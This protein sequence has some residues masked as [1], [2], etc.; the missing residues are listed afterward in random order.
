MNENVQMS[1]QPGFPIGVVCRMTGIAQETLRAWERRYALVTPSRAGGRNRLYSPDDV[2]RISLVKALVDAGHPVGSVASL[3]GAQLE[4]LRMATAPAVPAAREA[5]APPVLQASVAL[6]PGR[7]GVIGRSLATRLLGSP[8]RPTLEGAFSVD[9]LVDIAPEHRAQVLVLEMPTVQGDAAE[10]LAGALGRTGAGT[11]VVLYEFGARGAVASLEALGAI[12]LKGP[13]DPVAVERACAT[14]LACLDT[15]SERRVAGLPARRFSAE[16][17]ARIVARAPAIACECP[18]HLA[19]LIG[20]LAAFERF[21]GECENRSPADAHIHR[22]LQRMA[23]SARA[24]IEASLERVL[25]FEGISTDG[26]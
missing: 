13:V 15:E 5:K 8:G 3:D 25:A 20:S 21:S 7:V 12:C 10:A 23:A 18:R 14:A 26:E 9:A 6:A 4:A 16:Q 2:K 17:L 22:D 24:M 1:A 19:G 11:A